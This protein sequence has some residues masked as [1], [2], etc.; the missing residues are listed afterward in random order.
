MDSVV[1]LYMHCAVQVRLCPEGGRVDGPGQHRYVHPVGRQCIGGREI[2]R[3]CVPGERCCC[4]AAAQLLQ[5]ECT[6]YVVLQ[7]R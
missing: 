3:S 5:V 6:R 1:V 2:A 4:S 7:S